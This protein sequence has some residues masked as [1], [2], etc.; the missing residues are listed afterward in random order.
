MR[1]GIGAKLYIAIAAFLGCIV[2]GFAFNQIVTR[3]NSAV[4]NDIRERDFPLFDTA[5]KI[6]FNFKQLQESLQNALITGDIEDLDRARA[7][8]LTIEKSIQR[9]SLVEGSDTANT[10]GLEMRFNAYFGPAFA[11]TEKVVRGQAD[12]GSITEDIRAMQV[13]VRDFEVHL[14]NFQADRYSRFTEAIASANRQAEKSILLGY[15]TM[16]FSFFVTLVLTYMT[17]AFIKRPITELAEASVSLRKGR[18]PDPLEVRQSDE[19]G[20]LTQEFN[21]MT[22]QIKT[23]RE[24]LEFIVDQGIL[25]SSRHSLREL[26][27]TLYAGFGHLASTGR[28][29]VFLTNKNFLR[30]Q[31]SDGQVVPLER[32]GKLNEA[33]PVSLD[34]LKRNSRHIV[35]IRDPKTRDLLGLIV[36][37]RTSTEDYEE[38]RPVALALATSVAN[39]LI[40]IR[41]EEAMRLL[42]EKSNE[43]TTLLEQVPLGI[44]VLDIQ[45]RIFGEYSRHLQ[46]IFPDCQDEDFRILS[47][48]FEGELRNSVE[49]VITSSIGEDE[50]VFEMNSHILPGEVRIPADGE[51]RTLELAWNPICV[52]G[53][54]EF[55]MLTIRDVTEIRRLQKETELNNQK[56]RRLGQIFG[57]PDDRLRAYFATADQYMADLSL[58][59]TK[60]KALLTIKRHL[61]TLKGNSRSLNLSDLSSI[62]HKTEDQLMDE[63]P[64][65]SDDNFAEIQDCYHSYLVLARKIRHQTDQRSALCSPED[66]EQAIQMNFLTLD[67]TINEDVRHHIQLV[68]RVLVSQ[69]GASLAELTASIKDSIQEVTTRLKVPAPELRISE[70]TNLWFRKPALVALTGVMNHLIPNCID[71][72][73]DGGEGWINVCAL[74]SDDTFAI[75]VSDSG[76]GLN[77]MALRVSENETDEDTALRIFEP[78]VSTA[79]KVTD[80]SGRGIGLNAVVDILAPINGRIKIVFTDRISAAGF[81]PFLFRIEIPM[82]QLYPHAA[83]DEGRPS[84]SA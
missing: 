52:E 80:I 19:I 4:L 2:M 6:S 68:H 12:F 50:F 7:L 83:P 23:H 78:E 44:C 21:R 25:I 58:L 22:Q 11:I 35:N 9:I 65:I 51:N 20:R 81:R 49:S 31:L 29:R 82:D 26:S 45:F 43:I 57:A 24:N 39:S 59:R 56:V 69:A 64:W 1:L 30:S 32:E 41:L 66:L 36:F 67:K 47:K 33:D 61:H 62:I 28:I 40:S 76:K 37:F 14:E 16:I 18:Y 54:C 75:E 73:L 72:G 27:N 79:E 5:N 55:L 46:T 70:D 10:R 38:Q 77:L 60:S 17:R 34:S 48:M 53:V 71:H 74:S 8:G 42:S 63:K 3:S 13:A 84:R 15:A